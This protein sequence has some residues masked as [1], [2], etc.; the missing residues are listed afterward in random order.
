[1][2]R[3]LFLA[4][5]AMGASLGM[6]GRAEAQSQRDI[7][8]VAAEIIGT[9]L[10]TRMSAYDR[11]HDRRAFD[12]DRLW[13][14]ELNRRY[15]V[16]EVVLL[17]YRRSGLS[18]LQILG[19]VLLNLDRGTNRYV[20]REYRPVVTYRPAPRWEVDRWRNDRWRNDEW[21]HDDR[22]D[23]DRW[24]DRGRNDR[25][26]NDRD[27]DRWERDRRDNGNRGNQDGRNRNDRDRN[28]RD[29]NRWNDNRGNQGGQNGRNDRNR[30]GN[31]R[32]GQ[33]RRTKA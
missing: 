22:R 9:K 20:Y 24:D 26:R 11:L 17:R 5:L 14:R 30:D 6:A 31:S 27:R 1:M 7:D 28:G 10:G 8:R 25:G 13:C 21:R 32:N 23:H 2:I 12:D 19:N 33:N 15:G 18:W 29:D 4:A 3:N 16:E